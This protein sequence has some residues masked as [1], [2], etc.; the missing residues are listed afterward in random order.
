[1]ARIAG[2]TKSRNVTIA[3]TGLPG[4]PKTSPRPGPRPWRR[5][6]TPNHVGLP[7]RS[8]TPQ[9]TSSRAE[10]LER[11]LDMVVWTDRDAPRDHGDI[12]RQRTAQSGLGRLRG[13][14]DDL[15]EGELRAGRGD[16]RRERM[17]VGV[18]NR[19]RAEAARRAPAAR[20]PWSARRSAGAARTPP[21]P[22]RPRRA[23]RA[24]P[25]RARRRVRARRRP[26]RCPRR[27][28][29][30]LGRSRPRPRS[31][32]G[33][34]ERRRCPRRGRRHQRRRASSPRSRS[35]SP[36]PGR[37]PR[38]RDARLATRRR[39]PASPGVSAL[40]VFVSA[41]RTA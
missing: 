13:V 10:L 1:M 39:V 25:P 3:E 30:C 15:G 11:G 6:A 9:K 33:L 32:P 8:A 29:G 31:R 28:S 38:P 27:R 26:R 35:R 24:P 5:G 16:E 2:R 36:R 20:R 12:G 22:G 14:G 4:S 23:R 37:A 41:A 18:A 34:D 7:G 21:S 19:H 40:A 17:R